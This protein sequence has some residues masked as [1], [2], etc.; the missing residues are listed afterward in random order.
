[1]K[2]LNNWT[3]Y[4]NAD[5]YKAP[6]LWKLR[7]AGEIAGHPRHYDGKT[8]STSSVL[9]IKDDNGVLVAETRSGSLYKLGNP[10]KL[11]A[12]WLAEKRNTTPNNIPNCSYLSEA[13]IHYDLINELHKQ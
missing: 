2:T 10:D 4:Y 7:L 12:K 3:L 1:M 13:A 5:P 9:S 6:E 8:V 11:Y